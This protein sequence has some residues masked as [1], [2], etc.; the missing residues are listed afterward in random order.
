MNYLLRSMSSAERAFAYLA[1][2]PIRITYEQLLASPRAVI[3]RLAA[4]FG[5]DVPDNLAL[6]SGGYARVS[7]SNNEALRARFLADAEARIAEDVGVAGEA[8]AQG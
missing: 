7:T 3:E 8:E 5:V 1:I 6:G 2:R 4:P